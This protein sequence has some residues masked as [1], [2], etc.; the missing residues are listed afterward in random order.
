MLKREMEDVAVNVT[1]LPVRWAHRQGHVS[2]NESFPEQQ[3][4][5]DKV[6]FTRGVQ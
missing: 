4:K 5:S 1:Y 6:I 2:L 3:I